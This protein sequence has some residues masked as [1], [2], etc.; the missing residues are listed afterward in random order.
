MIAYHYK[1]W[2][3]AE[4]KLNVLIR[5]YGI[6]KYFNLKE[7]LVL[8]LEQKIFIIIILLKLEGYL[9]NLLIL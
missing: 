2:Y 6:I 4:I 5:S 7:L 9:N 8:F 3:D 1:R